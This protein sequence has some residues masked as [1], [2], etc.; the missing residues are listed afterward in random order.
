MGADLRRRRRTLGSA[1]GA[2]HGLAQRGQRP[3]HPLSGEE[4]HAQRD[5]ESRND[6]REVRPLALLPSPCLQLPGR[7]GDI[8]HAVRPSPAQRSRYVPSCE[9]RLQPAD[10]HAPPGQRQG[11]RVVGRMAQ[12]CVTRGDK[13]QARALG[14]VDPRLPGRAQSLK[15]LVLESLG[16]RIRIAGG[17][18]VHQECR[19][20]IG[21]RHRLVAEILQPGTR[22]PGERYL[23]SAEYQE[24]REH[25]GKDREALRQAHRRPL[26]SVDRRRRACRERGLSQSLDLD[27]HCHTTSAA[28]VRFAPRLRKPCAPTRAT[29]M[30]STGTT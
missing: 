22:G 10:H 9:R 29:P 28:W 18:D 1:M 27:A 25:R 17:S 2:G 8:E 26:G 16:Q 20:R 14:Q 30:A 6:R 21:Q 13:A 3:S 4:R 11:V 12:H 15:R 23:G 24:Q 5:Q 19:E 7:D